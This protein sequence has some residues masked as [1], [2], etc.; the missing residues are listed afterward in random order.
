[1]QVDELKPTYFWRF[2]E[3]G[4]PD[5]CWLWTGPKS[6]GSP[7][8]FIR[9]STMKPRKT[10]KFYDR[11]TPSDSPLHLAYNSSREGRTWELADKHL[12][13]VERTCENPFCFSPLHLVKRR[14]DQ[15]EM[16]YSPDPDQVVHD[17]EVTAMCL[18]IDE[19]DE[20]IHRPPEGDADGRGDRVR[21]G[22]ESRTRIY[23][24]HPRPKDAIAERYAT[25]DGG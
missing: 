19:I 1:M 17:L 21:G 9:K 23:Q 22:S 8:L 3:Q 12:H 11:A 25:R 5:Q 16:R 2:V 10:D 15:P 6:G 7:V 20:M 24:V 18:K 4:A 14:N 13:T